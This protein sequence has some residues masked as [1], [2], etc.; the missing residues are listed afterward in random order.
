M[1]LQPS[2]SCLPTF[3]SRLRETGPA[4]CRNAFSSGHAS[5]RG[6]QVTGPLSAPPSRENEEGGPTPTVGVV[7]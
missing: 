3:S 1:S 4:P 5:R 2:F 6:S 7:E